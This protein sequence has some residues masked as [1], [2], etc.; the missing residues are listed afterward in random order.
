MDPENCACN[1][2]VVLPYDVCT[3]QRWWFVLRI[4][5][6]THELQALGAF[7]GH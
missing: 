7:A 1:T 5:V 6:I 3:W 2:G 4:T